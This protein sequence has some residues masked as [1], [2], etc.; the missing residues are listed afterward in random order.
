MLVRL[1]VD[2][3]LEHNMK[4]HNDEIT[5]DGLEG[6]EKDRGLEKL[7]LPKLGLLDA[8][9]NLQEKDGVKVFA[10]L[11]S[12]ALGMEVSSGSS[13]SCSRSSEK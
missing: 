1:E 3:T 10:A 4:I 8:L 13:I 6:C 12:L 2:M 11:Y 7:L 9:H 5:N